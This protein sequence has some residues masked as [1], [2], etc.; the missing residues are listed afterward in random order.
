[1]DFH[2]NIH[3]YFFWKSKIENVK[4]LSS[5]KN[6]FNLKNII[7]RT[8]GLL[9]HVDNQYWIQIAQLIIIYR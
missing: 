6:K 9:I 1:M 2:C 4:V 3:I 5:V 8:F 7:L